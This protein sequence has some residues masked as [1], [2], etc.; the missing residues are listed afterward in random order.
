MQFLLD[1]PL[2]MAFADWVWSEDES[3]DVSP[4]FCVTSLPLMNGGC[5][6]RLLVKG[7]GVGIILGACLN[8]APVIYNIWTSKST[9]GLSGGALYLC[10]CSDLC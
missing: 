5:W 9:H 1:I 6:S 7:L 3:P 8:K 10:L 2:V 4:E